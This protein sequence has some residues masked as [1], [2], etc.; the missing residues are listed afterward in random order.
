[1]AALTS[2][3][4]VFESPLDRLLLAFDDPDLLP[5]TEDSEDDDDVL[6]PST[7]TDSG[8][9]EECL[10][11]GFDLL[12]LAFLLTEELLEVPSSDETPLVPT[13]SGSFAKDKSKLTSLPDSDDLRVSPLL[14]GLPIG[15][16]PDLLCGPGNSEDDV[17]ELKLSTLTDFCR[18]VGSCFLEGFDL[19]D[20]VFLLSSELLEVVRSVLFGSSAA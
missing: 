1:M 14:D 5:G 7:L 8:L 2:E 4:E 3:S 16:D 20:S 11:V 17:D 13:T 15:S 12:D 6:E 9:T 10:L 19:L 18:S